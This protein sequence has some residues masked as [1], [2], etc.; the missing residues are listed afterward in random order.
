MRE[1]GEER[2]ERGGGRGKQS[3]CGKRI[4]GMRYEST[5]KTGEF[6]SYF[7]QLFHS[8]LIDERK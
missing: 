5:R 2:R 1:G 8:D 3:E 4:E 7:F 6:L